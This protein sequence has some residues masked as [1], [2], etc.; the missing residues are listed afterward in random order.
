MPI[1]GLLRRFYLW[2]LDL[3]DAASRRRDMIPPRSMWWFV[4]PDNVKAEGLKF[5]NIL[6]ECGGLKANDRV[7]DVGCGIGRM[8]APLTGYLSSSGKYEGFDIV[9][10]GILWCQNN[11]TPRYPNFQFFHC[12][13]FNKTYNSR[14]LIQ[15]SEYRFPY[16]NCTFD[17]VFLTSVFTHMLP[18]DMENYLNEISRVLKE[19]GTCFFTFFL[20]NQES[21]GLIQ[22]HMGSQSFTHEIGGC[23]TTTLE[24][25]EAAIAF[26]EPYIR[27]LFDK[28]GLSICEPIR[29][30]SWCGREKFLD[31]QDILIARKI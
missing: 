1:K 26:P 19:G 25:P 23:F 30:G 20:M 6:V 12:D 11:I 5:R 28:G 7:L 2:A 27:R 16:E 18:I 29:Y 14:G 13:V 22:K 9:E 10:E 31:Y 15:A 3:T 24:N 8:A 17:F 21:E 4:G